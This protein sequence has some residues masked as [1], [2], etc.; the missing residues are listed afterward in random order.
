[1]KT[2][3]TN[4][5]AGRFSKL[6]PKE[7]CSPEEMMEIF[8]RDY[9]RDFPSGISELV[10]ARFHTIIPYRGKTAFAATG[11]ISGQSVIFYPS[12]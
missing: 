5:V 4:A 6:I 9:F 12:L 11:A 7:D 2:S 8:N 10:S 1:M 3:Y